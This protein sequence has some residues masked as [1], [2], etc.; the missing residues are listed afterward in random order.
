MCERWMVFWR[1]NLAIC[2][3]YYEVPIEDVG[4]VLSKS[5]NNRHIHA[6]DVIIQRVS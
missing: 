3:I 6:Y 4:I 5:F 2:S 1:D